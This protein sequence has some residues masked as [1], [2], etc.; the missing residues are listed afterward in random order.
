MPHG[1]AAKRRQGDERTVPVIHRLTVAAAPAV[2]LERRCGRVHA[3]TRAFAK[4]TLYAPSPE[5]VHEAPASTEGDTSAVLVTDPE[6][7]PA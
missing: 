4:V 1:M 3:G 7:V 6:L 2:R 5:P